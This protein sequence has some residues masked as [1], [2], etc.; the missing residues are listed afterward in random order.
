MKKFR[1]CGQDSECGF[2]IRSM[3]G[4]RE[5][6]GGCP[7]ARGCIR[8]CC[9]IGQR[10]CDRRPR[11]FFGRS[12]CCS[13]R[14]YKDVLIAAGY[15][16]EE[17][18][19]PLSPTRMSLQQ[20]SNKQILDEICRRTVGDTRRTPYSSASERSTSHPRRMDQHTLGVPPLGSFA[21][22]RP[23][24]S[25]PSRPAARRTHSHCRA[26]KGSKQRVGRA[27]HVGSSATA[28]DDRGDHP[29]ATAPSYCRSRCSRSASSSA[30]KVSI[31]TL[32]TG[33]GS[34][35]RTD[36]ERTCSACAFDARAKPDSSDST[37][38]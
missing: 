37:I 6:R 23:I 17:E 14:P 1:P 30:A 16:T 29:A 35:R 24:A 13:M 32:P 10:S 2:V 38:T 15:M 36:T 27:D 21:V 20:M 5:H 22:S 19:R 33:S 4:L 7:G 12:Q 11:K 8:R 31:P 9:V 34:R 18:N 28:P 25:K 26:G 3:L